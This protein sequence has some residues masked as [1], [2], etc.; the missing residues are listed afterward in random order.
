MGAD[1][2]RAVSEPTDVLIVTKN[3]A[4]KGQFGANL[5]HAMPRGDDMNASAFVRM[6]Q[7]PNTAGL[8]SVNFKSKR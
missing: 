1:H 5:Y 3:A 8:I 4:N 6:Q 2:S 7:K